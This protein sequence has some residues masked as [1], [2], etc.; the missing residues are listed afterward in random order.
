VLRSRIAISSPG[1]GSRRYAPHVFTEQ[2]V[3]MLSSW[4]AVY[5]D[6]EKPHLR[7]ERS[8][9]S[10]GL[11][12]Y[13]P[14]TKAGRRTVSISGRLASV[15]REHRAASGG[16]DSSFRVRPGRHST[17]RTCVNGFGC[18]CWSAPRF[19]IESVAERVGVTLPKP[20]APPEPPRGPGQPRMRVVDGG[21]Q[22]RS[23]NQRDGRKTVE[24][25]EVRSPKAG[26]RN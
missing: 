16:A 21:R 3:A 22:A 26:A 7:I 25:A 1:H 23:E 5:L 11:C 13:A 17:G 6:V 9:C 18:H 15:L 20:P 2:A 8:W 4:S 10:K 12:F 19:A 14:K 24:D